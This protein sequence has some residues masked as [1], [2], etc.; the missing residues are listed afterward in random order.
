MRVWLTRTYHFSASH[1][2][3]TAA[4]SDEKNALIFGKCNNPFGHGHNYSLE[5]TVSGEPDAETGLLVAPARLDRYVSEQVLQLFANKNINLDVPA[6]QNLVPTTENIAVV[7]LQLLAGKWSTY[8]GSGGL[9]LTRI[10]IQETDRNGFELL[11]DKSARR[12]QARE[13]AGMKQNVG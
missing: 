12:S 10:H 8:F 6:F 4:L 1:R 3:H 9:Q 2:L 13:N 5:V 11:L 7:I